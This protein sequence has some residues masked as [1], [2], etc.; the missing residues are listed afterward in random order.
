MIRFLLFQPVTST[1][2]PP[3]S[4]TPPG[5][6]T[7]TPSITLEELRS[8]DA[9]ADLAE[10]ARRE[11]KLKA[12]VAELVTTL[13]KLSR[14]SEHRHQQSA[15]FVN[16]LKKA[17]R[18]VASNRLS[19]QSTHCMCSQCTHCAWLMHSLYG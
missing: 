2:T 9:P 19:S 14:N 15:E 1:S 4:N 13:E 16:D 8:T 18:W 12:Q 17:N 7:V 11:K 10:A 6:N 5:G 3:T